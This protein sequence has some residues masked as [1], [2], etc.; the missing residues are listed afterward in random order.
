MFTTKLY[1]DTVCF[2]GK[3]A[4]AQLIPTGFVWDLTITAIGFNPTLML[5]DNFKSTCDRSKTKPLTTFCYLS[6]V[7]LTV[8]QILRLR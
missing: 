1:T 6:L 3:A 7:S 2:W 4:K 8:N 5:C